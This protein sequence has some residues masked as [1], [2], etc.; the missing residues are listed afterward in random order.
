MIIPIYHHVVTPFGN[1]AATISMPHRDDKRGKT[2][3]SM[4]LTSIGTLD[5]V[6]LEAVGFSAGYLDQAMLEIEGH[7]NGFPDA[8]YLKAAPNFTVNG[9]QYAGSVSVRRVH[10]DKP[11]GGGREEYVYGTHFSGMRR[12]MT[13]NAREKFAEWISEHWEE[14]ATPLRMA[15]V[16]Y[17][18]AQSYVEHTQRNFDDAA[19]ALSAARKER[20][21]AGAALERARQALDKETRAEVSA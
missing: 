12:E 10:Y 2:E 16:A 17:R 15:G 1:F 21:A 19:A 3:Y 18:S 14:I 9:V 6:P 4:N 8:D 5:T 20:V 7:E 11:Q 13:D